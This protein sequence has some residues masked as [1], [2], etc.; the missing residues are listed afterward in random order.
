MF[1]ILAII[2]SSIA[3]VANSVEH[4][5]NCIANVRGNFAYRSLG[6]IVVYGVRYCRYVTPMAAIIDAV[7]IFS[8]V[9][10]VFE[11]IIAP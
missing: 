7:A 6:H 1:I 11:D 8:A 10:R 9:I 4:C 5:R 3:N 2:M